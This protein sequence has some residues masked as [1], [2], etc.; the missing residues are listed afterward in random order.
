MVTEDDSVSDELEQQLA[1]TQPGDH[2]RMPYDS[3][4]ER[5]N[6]LTSFLLDQLRRLQ[7][8]EQAAR[9]LHRATL[10][11]GG[12]LDLEARLERV[13]DAALALTGAE[14]ARIILDDSATSELEFV[15]VRGAL[16]HMAGYR[17]P[18]GSG[19][20]GAVIDENRPVRIGDAQADP[21]SWDLKTVRRAGI[22]SW[23][24]VPL[25]DGSRAF[26]V[27]A[28]VSEVVDRFDAAD[29]TRLMSLAAL[30][31]SAIRE[32]RLRRQL[33]QELDERKRAEETLRAV[34]ETTPDVIIRV[35]RQLRYVYV[36]PAF[37]RVQG[38]PG[39]RLLG[40]SVGASGLAPSV[41]EGWRLTLQQVIATGREQTIEIEANVVGGE[42]VFQVRATPELGPD[43]RVE[44]VLT[45]SRD[46]TER[47]RREEQ[48]ARLYQ[49]LR[50]REERLQSLVQQALLAR[51]QDQRRMRGFEELQ[52][53]TQ[54]ER[55]TLMLLARGLTTRQIA[56]QL[57]IRPGTAKSYVE[58]VLDK[59]GVA[60]RTQAAARAMELGLSDEH[61][62]A[63]P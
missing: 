15:A 53:L 19:V 14:H 55:E 21:R 37:D 28:I 39:N 31:G 58:R 12:E 20:T 9:A 61:L 57:V 4:A 10:A 35:D 56:D 63:P 44:Y 49:E 38:V 22:R 42:R 34:V 36:N 5:T 50:E 51:E 26:G 8:S 25:A 54:R 18:R 32:A 40:L 46:I 24:G 23:L 16:G 60:N 27:L 29:E 45:V 11:I 41:A 30:A 3:D 52:R 62:P 47:I 43:G 7:A 33:E 2:L 1:P 6:A 59:L 13:L 17:Q 48:Q